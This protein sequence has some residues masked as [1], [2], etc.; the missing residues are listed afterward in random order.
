MLIKGISTLHT[1][2]DGVIFLLDSVHSPPFG[3][4]EHLPEL[5]NT[6]LRLFLSVR[7][8]FIVRRGEA[9]ACRIWAPLQ[10][11]L[12]ARTTHGVNKRVF[13]AAIDRLP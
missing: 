11:Q 2:P 13:K 5:R 6:N 12:I 3:T 10:T 4:L 7:N 8:M 9:H 1:L